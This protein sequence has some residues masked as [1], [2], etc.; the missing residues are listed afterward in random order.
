MT[1]SF[2]EGSRFAYPVWG[3]DHGGLVR[4]FNGRFVFVEAPNHSALAFGDPLPG[5]W[6]LHPAN[7]AAKEAEKEGNLEG[8]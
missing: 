8:Y 6:Q 5:G 4:K 7:E 3:T 1:G 2:L